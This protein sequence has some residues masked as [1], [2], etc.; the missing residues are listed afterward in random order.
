MIGL[1]GD[2]RSF[3]DNYMQNM[4]NICN[5]SKL[6]RHSDKLSKTTECY[7]STHANKCQLDEIDHDIGLVDEELMETL[8][9]LDVEVEEDD[10]DEPT[11]KRTKTSHDH[12]SLFDLRKKGNNRLG[13]CTDMLCELDTEST[14]NKIEIALEAGTRRRTNEAPA[15]IT[16]P[17]NNPDPLFRVIGRKTTRKSIVEGKEVTSVDA[18]GTADSTSEWGQEKEFDAD[19]QK[20]FEAT[21]ASFILT[22]H[23]DIENSCSDSTDHVPHL[24]LGRENSTSTRRTRLGLEKLCHKKKQLLLFMDGPG[25]SGKSTIIKEVLRCSR[26]FC[27]NIQHP[28]NEMTIQVTATS[29]VA[30]TLVIGETLHRACYL[31]RKKPSQK[32]NVML[33]NK[34]V[35]L[36]LMKCQWHQIIYWSI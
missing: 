30:A 24:L 20:A 11:N 28:F 9:G 21:V 26:E 32:S 25:G 22:F 23:H 31:S 33:S 36:L 4:Q 2:N 14:F 27:K 13:F 35:L 34:C 6:P 15:H 17:F 19:Q 1:P 5:A 18:T 7:A 16:G 12:V 10:T 29:G 8:F 3:I